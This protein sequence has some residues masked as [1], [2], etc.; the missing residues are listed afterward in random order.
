MTKKL[1]IHAGTYKTGS[2]AIQLYLS[3]AARTG[4]L[5]DATYPQTGRAL[6]IQHGNLTA[7]L[8]RGSA[9]VPER[10]GWD[11]LLALDPRNA[12]EPEHLQS[13]V[14]RGACQALGLLLPYLV[15]AQ[16]THLR[17]LLRAYP[18]SSSKESVHE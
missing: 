13:A 14:L 4:Q 17:Q 11:Q 1:V 7:E 9:F 12:L 5:G 6:G 3:R 18:T 15:P 10:G 2:S 16:Q 8:R